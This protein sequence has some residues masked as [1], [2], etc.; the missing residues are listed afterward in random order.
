MALP[1]VAHSVAD[2]HRE[3]PRES[4]EGRRLDAHRHECRDR[5]RGTL[6]DVGRPAV[7]G[8]RRHFEAEAGHRE[9]EGDDEQPVVPTG[10]SA[11]ASLSAMAP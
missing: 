4:G 8:H 10:V 2:G 5:R 9:D 1:H 7:E 6:V 11:V 3:Q